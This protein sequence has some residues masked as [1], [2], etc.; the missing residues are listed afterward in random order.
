MFKTC[1]FSTTTKEF[2]KYYTGKTMQYYI[3][4]P[5]NYPHTTFNFKFIS[6]YLYSNLFIAMHISKKISTWW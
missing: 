2:L 6:I 3:E 1:T 5:L 4:S